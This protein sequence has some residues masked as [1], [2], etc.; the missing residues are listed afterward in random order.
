MTLEEN[1]IRISELLGMIWRGKW[2]IL[3][4][5]LL[6]FLMGFIYATRVAQPVFSAS[7]TVAI[8][9]SRQPQVMD[10]D[11]IVGGLSGEQ[12]SLNTEMHLIRS[13]ELLG[14][15]VL[16]EGL[17]EDPEFNP[18]LAEVLPFSL[19]G[20]IGGIIGP[21]N[22]ELYTD[23]ELIRIAVDDLRTKLSVINP[24]DSFVFEIT[25][26][27]A[28]PEKAARLA[29]ALAG[30]YI[31]DQL[32]F[33]EEQ[34]QSAIEF[35]QL[36]TSE[37]QT[38]LNEAELEVKD[39]AANI[40]LVTPEELAVKSRQAKDLRDRLAELD[41]LI[42]ESQQIIANL[43]AFDPETPSNLTDDIR[44]NP[45]LSRLYDRYQQA[46]EVREELDSAI[47]SARVMRE[48]EITR[49][50]QQRLSLSA[51]VVDL[52]MEVEN[53]SRDLLDLQ[54]LQREAE[55]V[56]EIYGFFL[57]RLKEAE[58]QQGTQQAD[59]RL[60]SAAVVPLE[61]SAPRVAIILVLSLL[62]GAFL[63]LCYV[64]LREMSRG[65]IRT[66]SDLRSI[67]GLPV[68]GQIPMAPFNKR[69]GLVAF[70]E[71]NNNTAFS[72]AIRNLRTSAL[73]FDRDQ[74]PKS[75]LLSS[76]IPG[77]GKTTSSIA[78]A[79]SLCG[80]GRSV[81]LIEGDIRRRTLDSYFD[82]PKSLPTLLDFVSSKAD[83][84]TD[85]VKIEGLGFDYIGG[86]KSEKNPADFFSSGAF[87]SFLEAASETYDHLIIDAPPILPVADARIIGQ[88]VDMVLFAVAWDSTRA[89]LVAAGL[90]EFTSSGLKPAGVFL[91]KIDLAKAKKYGGETRYSNYYGKGAESY[92]TN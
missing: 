26:S 92:Y 43:I 20:I 63:G 29:N 3:F 66:S 70:L 22:P 48:R 42:T 82:L 12:P 14:R 11:A 78:L 6:V 90:E 84:A 44:E 76:S 4:A 5:S 80:M 91:T 55:A 16:Q 1:E 39:F 87:R 56:G 85:V 59:A 13:R 81:L 31:N 15:L 86:G 50:E 54:Q 34:S 61:A 51:A 19:E 71:G 75:I 88:S 58:V 40:D 2:I 49:L 57:A 30:I 64:I 52:E 9:S 27:A 10:F 60:L 74:E 38:E 41:G 65:G 45:L 73:A 7:A 46:P 32:F 89:E 68:M 53:E 36:R 69:K 18:Q 83:L 77:E 24:R 62:L 33:K 35:L 23:D 37:L 79:H 21:R 28:S 47:A 67:A 17:L 72:E 8:D 25:V